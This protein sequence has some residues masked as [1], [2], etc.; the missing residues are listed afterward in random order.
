ME[1]AASIAKRGL[2]V[3][4]RSVWRLLGKKHLE[5]LSRQRQVYL[6]DTNDHLIGDHSYDNGAVVWRWWPEA[7]LEI[8]RY[9][10]LSFGVNFFLDPG[11]HDARNVSTYPFVSELFRDEE[12]FDFGGVTMTK[13]AYRSLS[14]PSKHSI[15]VGNDVWIGTSASILPGVH[16]ADGAVILSNSVVSKDVGPY[17]VWGGV[18][19]RFLRKRFSDEQ[20]AKLLQIKWWDWDTEVVK[21]RIHDFHLDIAEFV[22]KYC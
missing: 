12:R 10:S 8:G 11:A 13:A 7:R 5:F 9:C 15:R 6:K 2:R 17:E 4:R 1:T 14:A 20:I 16:I 22:E 19:A 3:V 18:P 21:S